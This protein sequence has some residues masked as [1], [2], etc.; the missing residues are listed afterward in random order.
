M[1]RSFVP[2]HQREEHLAAR[3]RRSRTFEA[4]ACGS[5]PRL[6]V[7]GVVQP[8][9]IGGSVL[10]RIEGSKLPPNVGA[11]AETDDLGD[12]MYFEIH[13]TCSIGHDVV[14]ADMLGE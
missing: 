4:L 9:F 8:A 10:G 5:H 11:R 2:V 3:V 7:D 1:V 13:R 14:L 12:G 6:P